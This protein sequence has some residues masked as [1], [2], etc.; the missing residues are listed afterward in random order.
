VNW[1]DAW[2]YHPAALNNTLVVDGTN[3][4][5]GTRQFY[6]PVGCPAN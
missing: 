3:I 6:D 4:A 1:N 5:N 2:F